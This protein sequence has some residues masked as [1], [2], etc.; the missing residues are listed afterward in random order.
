M[1]WV[2]GVMKSSTITVHRP[3]SATI[4]NTWAVLREF[5]GLPLSYAD[6]SLV[7]LARKLS[8]DRVFSF[9]ADFRR[10]GLHVVPEA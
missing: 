2:T 6:A 3:D 8:I 4:D 7:A 10:C 5:S 9:D 1:R